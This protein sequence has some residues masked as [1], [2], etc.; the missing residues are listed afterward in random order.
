M[1]RSKSNNFPGL[2]VRKLG[3]DVS[4]LNLLIYLFLQSLASLIIL[5]TFNMFRQINQ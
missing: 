4:I 3:A 2:P 1:F 5:M